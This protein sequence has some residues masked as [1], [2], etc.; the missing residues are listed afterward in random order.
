MRNTRGMT[1]MEALVY[2]FVVIIAINIIAVTLAAFVNTHRR[3]SKNMT[4]LERATRLLRDVK[5]DLR[6]ARR[7]TVEGD[8]LKLVFE[9]EVEAVYAFV[10]EEG[11]VR[12]TG[13]GPARAYTESFDGVKFVSGP[14]RRVSVE[15]ELRK[16]EPDSEFRPRLHAV[17]FCR[18]G[19]VR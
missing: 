17:V 19:A 16:S 1:L 12:R 11:S 14:A 4:D 13:D 6:R 18:N 3:V 8:R 7:A 15:L 10:P 9:K 5:A 2:I